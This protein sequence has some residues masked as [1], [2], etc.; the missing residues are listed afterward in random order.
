MQWAMRRVLDDDPLLEACLRD[1]RYDAQIDD[2]RG[3]WLWQMVRAVD[4]ADRFRV[5]ILHALYSL[6]DDRNADQLCDLARCFAGAG[7]ETFRRR[8]Y[9]IVEQKPIA[10]SRWLG[11]EEII[12]LDGEPAFLFSARVRGKDLTT[13]GW[14][15]DDGS[16]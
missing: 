14:E 2:T 15:W 7:D 9:E 13:R 8:L 3:D 12:R 1:G 11:E 4:A 5:P 16:L 6:P 10:G